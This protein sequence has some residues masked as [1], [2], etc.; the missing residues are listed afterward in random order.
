MI[1]MMY[2]IFI[3]MLALNLSKQILQSFG[4][5]NEELTDTNIE[6]VERNNQFMQG[7]EEKAQEQAE[8]YLD[9]KLKAD[10]IREVSTGFYN[11][12]ESIKEGA[13]LSAEAKGIE[14]S[15]YSKLDNTAYYTEQ[16]FDGEELK[17]E[18]QEFIDQMDNFRNSF[19]QIASS[20]PKLVS[21]AEE[22]SSK[23]DTGDI[24]TEDGKPRRYLDYHYK[25]M[26]L[27]VGITKLSL[28]QSTLQNIEAQLLST[29][30]EGKLKIEASLTNFDAIV[31]PDKSSFFAGENFTGRIILGKNDPT[32]RAD[33]VII[34]GNELD[35]ESMQQGQTL[36]SFPAGGIGTKTIEGEFQ[37]TEEGELI[38]IPVSTSYEVVPRPNKATISADKMNVVYNGVSNPFTISFPGIDANKVSVSTPGL[39]KGKT[40]IDKGRKKKLTGASDYELDLSKLPPQLRGKKQVIINVTGTLPSGQKVTSKVPFRIKQLPVPYGTLDNDNPNSLKKSELINSTV[41]A[42]FGPDFD[43]NLPLRV[44]EF[45]ITV[46]GV[47]S[48]VVSGSDLD[49]PAKQLVQRARNNSIVTIT[50]IQTSASGS[51]TEIKNATGISFTLVN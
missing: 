40:I 14:R 46:A 19:V 44:R 23:F 22:V 48:R 34:N 24:P 26:P 21:I 28:L 51:T 45:K 9:L 31:V 49:G 10:S 13:Y 25:E 47:G 27:I 36:L 4:T 1:N 37:F 6:L 35:D 43:F 32:L 15:N 29:M 33:K 7:L 17:P 5:M 50:D 41:T 38:S 11:Y 16:F 39:K 42:T 30:L 3:A 12:L 8:K 18:G 2:L 20:D